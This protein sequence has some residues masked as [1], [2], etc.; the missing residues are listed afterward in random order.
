MSKPVKDIKRK[1]INQTKKEQPNF[2]T[3]R[4]KLLKFCEYI[5]IN[6]NCQPLYCSLQTLPSGFCTSLNL[7]SYRRILLN[8]SCYAICRRDS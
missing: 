1:V 4:D 8:N 3:L 6:S 2:T 5:F 7:G